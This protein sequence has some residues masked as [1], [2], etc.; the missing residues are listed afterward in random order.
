MDA[1]G[2]SRPIAALAKLDRRTTL[3]SLCRLALYLDRRNIIHPIQR[4]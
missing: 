4:D 3:P 2:R 1:A